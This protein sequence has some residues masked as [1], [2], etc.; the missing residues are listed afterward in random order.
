MIDRLDPRPGQTVLE[1]AAGRGEVAFAA[2][3]RLQ[4]GGRLIVTDGAEAM[5]EAAKRHGEQLGVEGAEY[6]PMELEWVDESAASIDG[7]LCRFGYML[8]VDPEAALREA[9]RVLKPGGRLVF[10]VWDGPEANPWLAIPPQEAIRAGHL[11]S[12]PADTPG[13]FSLSV[14]AELREVVEAAGFVDPAIE[15]L[16]LS[17]PAPSMDACWEQLRAMSSTMRRVLATL[18]P[19]DHYTL[20]DAIEARW[21][22]YVAADGSVAIPGRALGVVGEA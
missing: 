6:R 20:R 8:A 18:S 4:P 21:E 7:L 16:D 11:E 1:L 15:P 14:L 12:P 9:R 2:A 19:A 10:T 3:P 13:P 17:F 22:P 5:V